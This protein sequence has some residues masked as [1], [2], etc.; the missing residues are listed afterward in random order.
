MSMYFNPASAGNI[1]RGCEANGNHTVREAVPAHS[2]RKQN[3]R[4]GVAAALCQWSILSIAPTHC[5]QGER[6]TGAKS[7]VRST[8]VRH[9]LKGKFVL[10]SS[11]PL[12]GVERCFHTLTR[13]NPNY[14]PQTREPILA[15]THSCANPVGAREH[16]RART[17]TRTH[18]HLH[19]PTQTC[20]RKHRRGSRQPVPALL[21][22][23]RVS[24]A[25]DVRKLLS[26]L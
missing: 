18:T 11:P 23:T 3:D 24:A 1:Y 16:T 6:R 13:T 26:A 20:A 21:P 14:D 4:E 10:A 22:R 8:K 5:C 9:S 7:Q 2:M 15:E 19:A 17:H 12:H 25:C